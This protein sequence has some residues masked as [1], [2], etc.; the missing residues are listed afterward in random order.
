V[1]HIRSDTYKKDR[2]ELAQAVLK[3]DRQ[4]LRPSPSEAE[5]DC[6]LWAGCLVLGVPDFENETEP[7]WRSDI[8]KILEKDMKSLRQLNEVVKKFL[9]SEYLGA[10]VTHKLPDLQTS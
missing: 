7:T 5:V 3:C 9:W 4:P 2:E 1:F 6:V 8:Q 10:S